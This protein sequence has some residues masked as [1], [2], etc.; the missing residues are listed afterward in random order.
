LK[1]N[2]QNLHCH[3]VRRCSLLVCASRL[4]GLVTKRVGAR[5]LAAA[6]RAPPDNYKNKALPLVKY[7][8][9]YVYNGSIIVLVLV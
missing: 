9:R 3:S 1:Q 8:P 6:T 2:E 5:P 4:A 7:I